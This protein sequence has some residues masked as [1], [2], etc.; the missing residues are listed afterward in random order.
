MSIEFDIKE[1][2][3]STMVLFSVI[4]ILGSIP[5]IVDLRSKT[6]H[7]QSEKATIVSMVLMILFLYVGQSIL[8]WIGIDIA[9][10]AIAGSL[11]IFFLALEMILGIRLYKD[12]SPDTSSI[13]PLAFPLIAGAGSLTTIL[14]IRSQYRSENIIVGIIINMILVYIVLKTTSTIER[15]IGKNGLNVIRRVFG[16]ILLAI[17]VKLFKANINI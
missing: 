10:F 14:A 5:I 4:D 11:V 3:T 13:V 7:I 1:I 9:S 8:T 16:V 12:A 15:V 17:A 2:L 6:G